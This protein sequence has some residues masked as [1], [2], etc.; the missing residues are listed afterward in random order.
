VASVVF[1]VASLHLLYVNT[2]LLPKAL[3]P[4]LWRRAALVGMACFYGIFAALALRSLL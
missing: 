2:R 4:P 1:V 3:H